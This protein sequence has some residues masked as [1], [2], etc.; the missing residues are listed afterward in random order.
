MNTD[1]KARGV[2]STKAN[3]EGE[4]KGEQKNQKKREKSEGRKE[5]TGGNEKKKKTSTTTK[6]PF[7][8]LRH[9]GLRF[10]PLRVPS[11]A[12]DTDKRHENV[13]GDGQTVWR[14]VDQPGI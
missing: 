6:I 4:Q 2:P 7:A 14:D 1:T 8:I 3:N 11:F 5:K 13:T 10:P 12:F 9:C